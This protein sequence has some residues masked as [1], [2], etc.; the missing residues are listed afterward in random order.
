MLTR[1]TQVLS[2]TAILIAAIAS[3]DARDADACSIYQ[4]TAMPP[5]TSEARE[6]PANG[7]FFG[8]DEAR[9]SWVN[10]NGDPIELEE[11]NEPKFPEQLDIRRPVTTL[12]PGQ[13]IQL[14]GCASE[15]CAWTIVDKDTTA[16]SKPRI[17]DVSIFI[18]RERRFD[19]ELHACTNGNGKDH[20]VSFTLELDEKLDAPDM[21]MTW[22]KYT[23]D[24]DVI[25]VQEPITEERLDIVFSHSEDGDGTKIYS[26]DDLSEAN[27][28][29]RPDAPFCIQAAVMDAAGNLSEWS[30]RE[31]FDPT[32]RRASYTNGGGACSSASLGSQVPAQ[33][34]LLGLLFG[35]VA[36][37]LRRRR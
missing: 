21:H 3:I 18:D 9:Y 26:F 24:S 12:T 25:P 7:V 27:A 29:L 1:A 4:E 15:D 19:R 17:T 13:T 20:S 31:C 22:V 6:I 37:G 11:V 30:E 8:E 35:F 36:L 32:D 2:L 5:A 10:E 34:P 14:E 16:P 33:A 28:V 23:G